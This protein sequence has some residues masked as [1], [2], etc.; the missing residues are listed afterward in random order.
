MQCHLDFLMELLFLKSF[1]HF[2]VFFFS[3]LTFEMNISMHTFLY[4][5]FYHL[6]DIKS[7]FFGL[8]LFINAFRH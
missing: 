5:K 2:K 3:V 1:G 6:Y 7:F 8:A 4:Y